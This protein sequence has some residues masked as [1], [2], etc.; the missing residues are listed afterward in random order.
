MKY[1][2]NTLLVLLV[3][4]FATIDTRSIENDVNIEQ[5]VERRISTDRKLLTT[6]AAFRHRFEHSP[7]FQEFNW[8]IRD[9][10]GASYCEFCDIF[11]PAVSLIDG[12]IS[13]VF[14]NLL[15]RFDF[16]SM[17]IKRLT[18]RMLPLLYAKISNYSLMSMFVSE[19]FMS[20]GY[21]VVL[22]SICICIA[23]M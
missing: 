21:S 11:V 9:Q 17:L 7:N 18:W 23:L 15:L 1:L 22:L 6:V 5:L 14:L 3:F 10:L 4:G 13:N 20:I 2:I 8:A 19:L 16:S 12:E